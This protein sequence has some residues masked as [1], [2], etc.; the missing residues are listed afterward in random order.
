VVLPRLMQSVLAPKFRASVGGA[1]PEVS[2]V[3]SLAGQALAVLVVGVCLVILGTIYRDQHHVQFGA[4]FVM[5][6]P[7]IY[8]VVR[9]LFVAES[10]TL[11]TLVYPVVVFTLWVLKPDVD[12]LG[13]I[14]YLAG[15]AA[16]LSL[17]LAVVLPSKGLF[18]TSTGALVNE[19]KN[20]LPWGSLVGFLT[21]ANN[22]GQFLAVSVPL[23]C[24]IRRP[25]HRY[26]LLLITLFALVW[27]SFLAVGIAALAAAAIAIVPWAVRH[28]M[29]VTVA[30]VPFVAGCLLP[31]F[32]HDP[33][34]FSNRGLI[35]MQSA[36]WWRESEWFGLGANWFGDVGQTSQRISATA[37]HGHNQLM[38]FLVTGGLVLAL[39]VAVQLVFVIVRAGRLAGQGTMVGAVYLAALAGTC[40]L[41]KS[42]AIVDNTLMFPVVVLPLAVIAFCAMSDDDV[43][44]SPRR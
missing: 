39:A 23:I 16:L 20:I 6:L 38:H 40:V 29:A 17:L 4:L 19:D 32:V 5:V 7:W 28:A 9:D 11:P 37:F 26:P 22:L 30:A 27:T 13:L 34:A 44:T 15:A 3:A 1:T 33:E 2:G 41:E 8:L 43:S 25:A 14:G 36:L 12:T 42:F 21:H 18:V 35:W 10:P 24:A 31:W